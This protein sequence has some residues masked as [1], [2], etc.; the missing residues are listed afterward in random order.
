MDIFLIKFA[1]LVLER[2]TAN[3]LVCIT[4]VVI[5]VVLVRNEVKI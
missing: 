2:E 5:L 3:N 1:K 4:F